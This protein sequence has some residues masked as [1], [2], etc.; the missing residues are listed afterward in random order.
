MIDHLGLRFTA[1][2]FHQ[3]NIHKFS[4]SYIEISFVYGSGLQNEVLILRVIYA[5][6]D[7][8]FPFQGA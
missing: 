7:F 1:I 8:Y 3:Y 4:C 6:R 5:Y 2:H